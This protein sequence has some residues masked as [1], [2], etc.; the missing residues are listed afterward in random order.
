DDRFYFTCAAFF[1]QRLID[2]LT[3]RS[4]GAAGVSIVNRSDDWGALALNGPKSRDILGACSNA[5]LDNAAFPWLGV[6]QIEIEGRPMWAF[7]MS[8]AGELG[9]ELHGP[10]KH[11]LSVYNA[12]FDAGAPYGIADYGSFAMN[13]MRMEKMFK[14]AGELTNEVTLPEAD[15]MRFVRLDKPDFVGKAATQAALAKPLS[16]I[17]AYLEIETDGDSDGHGGEAVLAEGVCIGSTSSVAFG[18]GVQKLLAFAY[19]KPQYGEPGTKLEVM[20][21]GEPRPAVVLGAPV[22]DPANKRPRA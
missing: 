9:W 14:G 20:I 19:L 18:H 15:V 17:C 2:Y 4:N 7:R 8:Y 13:A 1:E 10:H 21:M 22:Y 3:Y 5:P 16:W 11:L 12:L 6:R